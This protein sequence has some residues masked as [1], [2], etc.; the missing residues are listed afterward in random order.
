MLASVGKYKAKT[1]GRNLFD[2]LVNAER[3][4][5][6]RVVAETEH[7]IAYVPDA[8]RWPVEVNLAPLRRV[9]D[10]PSL[11]DEERDDFGP[12]YL[13]ILNGLDAYFDQ[14][15]PY[16]SAW[17]QAPVRDGREDFGA[18]LQLYSIRR[19]PDKLK[20]LAGSESGMGAWVNDV[21]PESIAT[22]L[23]EVL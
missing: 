6:V 5:K 15:L 9:P 2:D 13:R 1:G 22:R 19:A 21:A 11:T 20:Y 8:A 3:A 10:L 23:R 12:L 18:Y 4:A 7:W 17:H 16:I 14:T